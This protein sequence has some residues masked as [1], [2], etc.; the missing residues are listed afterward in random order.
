M[1]ISVT[2]SSSSNALHTGITRSR[3]TFNFTV[4]EVRSTTVPYFSR[5]L[6]T[7]ATFGSL[8]RDHLEI[9]EAVEHFVQFA[10][11][12]NAAMV[13]NDHASAQR[14]DICHVMAGEEDGR[15]LRLVVAAQELPDRLLR[16][17]VEPDRRLIQEQ[18]AACGAATRSTP[19]SCARRGRVAH[20]DVEL[21]AHAQHLAQ[22]IDGLL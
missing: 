5:S 3:L 18:H 20:H 22:V 6:S 4:P 15:F 11:E 21:V 12:E 7:R 10:V 16:H 2:G 8:D 9:G 1:S 19:I 13:D 14:L 17:D